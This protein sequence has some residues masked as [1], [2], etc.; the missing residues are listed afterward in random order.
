[1][2]T[3]IIEHVGTVISIEVVGDAQRLTIGAVGLAL[4]LELGDS[5]SVDGACQTVVESSDETFSVETIGTT[6][7]RTIL[8]EYSVG[9]PVNLERAMKVGQRLDG[10]LVQGHV[11]G[12]GTLEAVSAEDGFWL[13][14]FQ[15]PAEIWSQT[16]LH[17]SI[18]LNGISLT[19]NAMSEPH[20]CQVG[21]IPH[22]WDRT[23]L[24]SLDLGGRVN[25]EGDLIGKY[26]GRMLSAHQG[27]WVRKGSQANTDN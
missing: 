9:T 11:D 22:T 16:I 7:S 25:I 20:S 3:G 4:E 27:E 17:G 18:S 23:N 5:I 14:T 15:V 13:M 26:V 24:S 6:L 2:F 10:H 1:M 12:V 8:G 19:V 21:I